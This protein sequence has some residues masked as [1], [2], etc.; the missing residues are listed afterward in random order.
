MKGNVNIMI[1]EVLEFEA[2][3]RIDNEYAYGSSSKFNGLFRINMNTGECSYLQMFPKEKASARRLHTKAFLY[4]NK[5]FFIP[6]TAKN[7]SI[8]DI[9]KDNITSIE[10]KEVDSQK[11]PWYLAGNKFNDG[12]LYKDSLFLV[13]S[14]YPAIVKLDLKTYLLEYYSQWIKGEFA[15]RKSPAIVGEMFYVPSIKGNE[16]LCFDMETRKAKLYNVGEDNN[17]SW[18]ICR[19][20]DDLWIS[21]QEPGPIIQWNIYTGNVKEYSNYPPQYDDGGFAC[22]KIYKTQEKVGLLPAYANMALLVDIKTGKIYQ[23][24][25]LKKNKGELTSY[26]FDDGNCTYIRNIKDDFTE[27]FCFNTWENTIIPFEFSFADGHDKY[28]KD[29]FAIEKMLRES[30][31]INLVDFIRGV[32][33]C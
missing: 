23:N 4:E 2:V 21:P 19:I 30:T 17:G 22:T 14:T 8:Y 27:Y 29:C 9:E 28:L 16:V 12:V 13:A 3:A 1:K 5:I 31:R 15:F 24:D 25:V 18:G 7:I 11:Y 20:E 26:L 32:D 6:C 10:L 33:K